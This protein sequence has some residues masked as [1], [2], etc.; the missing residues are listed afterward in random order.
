MP[1]TV[2]GIGFALESGVHA[3]AHVARHFG[4]RGLS[5][6]AA[7][8]FRRATALRVLPKFWA[9][10]AFVRGMR[11]ARARDVGSA[12]LSKGVQKAVAVGIAALLGE[13]ARASA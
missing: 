7:Q 4:P 2:E 3:A 1:G 10:E 11:S 9:G 13:R 12:V 5:P 6:L 8:G